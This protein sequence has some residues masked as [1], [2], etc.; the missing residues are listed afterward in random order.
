MLTWAH[1][2]NLASSFAI[3][4]ST[5]K[6]PSAATLFLSMLSS[7]SL[8]LSLLLSTTTPCNPPGPQSVIVVVDNDRI[9]SGTASASALKVDTRDFDLPSGELSVPLA[10]IT[11]SSLV[12][13]VFADACGDPR[14]RRR[15]DHGGSTRAPRISSAAPQA[16]AHLHVVCHENHHS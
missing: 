8:L 12:A 2:D 6:P 13:F 15:L 1:I 11:P 14:G 3:C 9:M 7:P 5:T 16:L 10:L 4:S